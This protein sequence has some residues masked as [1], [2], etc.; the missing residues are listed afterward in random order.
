M[1]LDRSL[2]LVPVRRP[3]R[4]DPVVARRQRLIQRIG[5]QV[6]LVK[7]HKQGSSLVGE[8]GVPRRGSPWWWMDDNSIYF[9]PIKYGKKT[10]E[11]GKGKY[12]IQCRSLDDVEDALEKVR[13]HVL[14]GDLDS[15]LRSAAED[16][17][18]KFKSK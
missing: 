9:L 14:K 8:D 11:I 12:A 3:T 1:A 18:A 6:D 17:R 15:I 2:N 13:T 10:L 7:A 5:T 16:I 4:T